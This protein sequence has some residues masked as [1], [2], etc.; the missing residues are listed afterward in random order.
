MKR[1]LLHRAVTVPILFVGAML[2]FT[3]GRRTANVPGDSR[4]AVASF[5]ESPMCRAGLYDL[6]YHF[7]FVR[8]VGIFPQRWIKIALG[9]KITKAKKK[10]KRFAEAPRVRSHGPSVGFVRYVA[11]S[12]IF[13]SLRAAS[14]P[15][16][17]TLGG[18][19]A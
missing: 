16:R 19:L 14:S 4:G 7:F 9:A 5:L 10:K 18:H 11:G 8:R 12:P 3:C 13:W 2:L 15:T 6:W 17:V 1:R